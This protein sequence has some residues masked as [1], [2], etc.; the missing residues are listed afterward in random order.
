V[1]IDQIRAELETRVMRFSEQQRRLLIWMLE[2]E[3]GNTSFSDEPNAIDAY[4]PTEIPWSSKEFLGSK[5]TENDRSTLSRILGTLEERTLIT[6][7]GREGIPP[8]TT[9]VMFTK[10]GRF[11]AE[12]LQRGY[13]IGTP[14]KGK[15]SSTKREPARLKALDLSSNLLKKELERVESALEKEMRD[16]T[17]LKIINDQGEVARTRRDVEACRAGLK[18]AI[19]TFET[20][21]A[22]LSKQF[23]DRLLGWLKTEIKK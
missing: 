22:E 7:K 19:E 12:G 15:R 17:S 16:Y 9:H 6:L 11:I 18:N 20:E 5:P 1:S 4:I 3:P 13:K 8:R 10:P 21:R 23:N 2:Q 14:S